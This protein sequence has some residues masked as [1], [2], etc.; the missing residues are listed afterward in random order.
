VVFIEV[1]IRFL[2]GAALVSQRAGEH[3]AGLEGCTLGATGLPP[4]QGELAAAPQAL[5]LPQPLGVL[6][7]SEGLDQVRHGVSPVSVGAS[8]VRVFVVVVPVR[9]PPRSCEDVHAA[10][11]E[12]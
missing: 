10:A 5:R 8:V 1:A 11:S 7:P 4:C 3:E 9:P 12:E 6:D 2:M